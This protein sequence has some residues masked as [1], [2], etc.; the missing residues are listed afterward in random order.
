MYALLND[1]FEIHG[2]PLNHLDKR[3]LIGLSPKAFGAVGDGVTDDTAAIQAWLD[4]P[5]KVKTLPE[6]DYSATGGFVS[7]TDGLFITGPGRLVAKTAESILLTFSGKDVT[8][9]GL[10]IDGKNLARYGLRMTGEN[11]CVRDCVVENI[12]STTSTARGIESSTLGLVRIYNNVIR[13]VVAVGNATQG[14]SNGLSRGILLHANDNKTSPAF[15]YNNYIENI[16]G[17]E[18]DAIAVL[19]SNAVTEADVY[20]SGW[21]KITNNTIRNC[22]RRHIK[23]QGSNVWVD[24]NW[25]YNLPGYVQ[26]NPSSVID[27]VQGSHIRI[28]NNVVKEAGNSAPMSVAGPSTTV[29]VKDVEISGNRFEEGDNASPVIYVV[30][31]DN[32]SITG[33]YLSG[34]QYYVSGSTCTDL[35]VAYNDC[36]GGTSTNNAFNFTSSGAGKIRYNTIPT[37]RSVGASTNIVFEG[38]G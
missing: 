34:G 10:K 37:G 24:G 12:K 28:T 2:A 15:C 16:G 25:C 38:N 5:A 30:H 8:V 18:S 6:G 35:V 4:A 27:I 33:N 1:K 13:N 29:R 31:A 26:Q 22:G 19:Y 20:E 23:L 36:R 32:V 17:E 7:S 9:D 21:T 3:Y 11:H 14:D